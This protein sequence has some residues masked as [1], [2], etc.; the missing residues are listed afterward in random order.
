MVE[1]F[2]LA[3][4]A[5]IK[6]LDRE[7]RTAAL[8]DRKLSRPIPSARRL[9][10]SAI[11]C[12]AEEIALHHSLATRRNIHGAHERGLKSVVWTVDGPAWIERAIKKGIHAIITNQPARMFQRRAQLMK[13]KNETMNERKSKSWLQP[14][15]LLD[16]GFWLL[17]PAFRSSFPFI[18]EPA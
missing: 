9:A 17:T 15:P 4:I 2:D 5:E 12:G 8:F 11:D 7:I 18:Y 16:S 14:N 10:E 13:S 3:A 6:R 1:S